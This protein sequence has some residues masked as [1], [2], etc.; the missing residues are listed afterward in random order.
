MTNAIYKVRR[1]AFAL[2]G[3]MLADFRAARVNG[4]YGFYDILNKTFSPGEGGT[5]TAGDEIDSPAMNSLYTTIKFANGDTVALP[6]E[7][8]LCADIFQSTG[9]RSST[10][11]VY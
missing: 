4:H 9:Y 10:A 3:V 5:F 7:G 8:Q 11:W 2:N 6:A 1:V